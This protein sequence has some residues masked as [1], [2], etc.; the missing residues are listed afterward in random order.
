MEEKEIDGYKFVEF[1]GWNEWAEYFKPI[2]NHL[3]SD[4]D[5]FMFE[6]YG[7]ELEFVRNYQFNNVWT[8]EQAEM[9]MIISNGYHLVNR[10]GYYLTEVPWKPD[11]IYTVILSEDVECECY[12]EEA[13]DNGEREDAGDPNCKKCEGYGLVTE[14][15]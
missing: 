7:E 6:T 3:S 4:P 11:T 14:Y 12:D 2:N 10:I 9:S 15:L 8:Y 1:K 5:E 13:W